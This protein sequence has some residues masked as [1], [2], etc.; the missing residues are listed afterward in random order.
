MK[1]GLFLSSM[2]KWGSAAT[3]WGALARNDE[4]WDKTF[5]HHHSHPDGTSIHSWSIFTQRFHYPELSLW[6]TGT[7][8]GLGNSGGW[9]LVWVWSHKW[10]LLEQVGGFIR[11]TWAINV[12]VKEERKEDMNGIRTCGRLKIQQRR[13]GGIQSKTKQASA[14]NREW[15]LRESEEIFP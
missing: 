13:K 7:G 11:R 3:Q 12:D 4:I 6:N 14:Q 15:W 9:A 10:L 8:R 1:W 2:D 5:T